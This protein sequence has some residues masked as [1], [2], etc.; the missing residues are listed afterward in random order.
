MTDRDLELEL[1][2]DR[3]QWSGQPVICQACGQAG[4]PVMAD[5]GW[6]MPVHPDPSHWRKDAIC[7]GALA[8]VTASQCPVEMEARIED[9]FVRSMPPEHQDIPE[10][11]RAVED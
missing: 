3:P 10:A 11:S 4:V 1:A 8:A 7:P 6:R 2:E 9:H 5:D